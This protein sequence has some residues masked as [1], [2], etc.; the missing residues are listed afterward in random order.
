MN[1]TPTPGP[2][3][4]APEPGR[5]TIGGTP[6]QMAKSAGFVMAAIAAFFFGT[7]AVSLATGDHIIGSIVGGL[8]TA[9]AIW[10]WRRARMIPEERARAEE[11]ATTR[12]I[13]P[14]GSA[15]PLAA[16]DAITIAAALVLWWLFANITV[17]W[18]RNEMASPG[19]EATNRVLGSTTALVAIFFVVIAAPIAEEALMRG[20]AYPVARRHLTVIPAALLTAGIF[21]L[22]HGNIMQ[23]II[24]LP[25]GVICALIYELTGQLRYAI[26]AHV[27]F[28]A[29]GLAVPLSQLSKISDHAAAPAVSALLFI[30][31]TAATMAVYAATAEYGR[32]HELK[33][34][35]PPQDPGEGPGD[36]R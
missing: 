3:A 10:L 13:S 5:R 16:K 15:N 14:L 2:A 22:I 6:K 12:D 35:G 23:L 34:M 18:L 11:R 19:F 28:N 17:G 26:A 33:L 7:S 9:G 25:L 29:V 36:K 8:A 30:M 32:R 4:G 31:A 21:A 24:A 1:T 27:G 20:L